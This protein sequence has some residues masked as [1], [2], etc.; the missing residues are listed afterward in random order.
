MTDDVNV[1]KLVS[2]IGSIPNLL[3]S[4]CRQPKYERG[5]SPHTMMC[6]FVAMLAHSEEAD[7]RQWGSSQVDAK[8]VI[9]DIPGRGGSHDGDWL[10]RS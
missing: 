1:P 7:L 2:L 9:H 4:Y 10:L 6:R 5:M 8:L 3:R